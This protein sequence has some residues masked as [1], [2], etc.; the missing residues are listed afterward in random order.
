VTALRR[1]I[2]SAFESIE[3]LTAGMPDRVIN[4]VLAEYAGQ[5][6]KERIM[7]R[8]RAPLSF[9]AVFLLIAVAVAVFVGGRLIHDWNTFHNAT[10]AGHNN[11]TQSQFDAQV[12]LLEQ[13]PLRLPT[14]KAGTACPDTG[15]NNLLG[16]Q[17]GSG[18]VYADG[19]SAQ[20]SAWGNFF[21]IPWITDPHLGGPVLI[22]GTDL[23]GRSVVFTG[24]GAYGPVVAS[25]PAQASPALHSELVFDAGHPTQREN[26]Y[27][28]FAVH[29]GLPKDAG[30]C[31]G[32]Q[33]DGPAFTETLT[34]AG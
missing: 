31:A 34:A 15:N 6:R 28:I 22:R 13:R 8:M 26:G 27:G 24:S 3:P 14:V 32:F 18:P 30:P 33:I 19:S 9:V 12:A 17:Y 21:N 11:Q 25:D 2:H 29:Q 5:R 16:H 20:A 23:Q 7:F 1:D 10:P 4:T